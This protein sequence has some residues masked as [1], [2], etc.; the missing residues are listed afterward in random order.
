MKRFVFLFT[1][2][3]ALLPTTWLLVFR[4]SPDFIEWL[5]APAWTSGFVLLFWPSWVLMLGDAE[6]TSVILPTLSVLLNA[7]LYG[8]LGALVWSG[9]KRSKLILGA[10]AVGIVTGWYT[11]LELY[12]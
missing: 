9:M 11:L 12:Y 7:L 4:V 8:I 2:A 5:T 3:G 1:A 6:N 10:T